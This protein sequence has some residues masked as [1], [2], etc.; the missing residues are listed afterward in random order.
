MIRKYN[1]M[2]T[3]ILSPTQG[4]SEPPLDKGDILY[5]TITNRD[6]SKFNVIIK[7]WMSG[8][9]S[10][11]HTYEVIGECSVPVNYLNEMVIDIIQKEI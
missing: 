5:E 4:R 6:G 8:P 2:L 3:D 1:D 7:Y 9:D 10:F 11:D